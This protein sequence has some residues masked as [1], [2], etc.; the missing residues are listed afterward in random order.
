MGGGS[1]SG[2]GDAPAA[3]HPGMLKDGKWLMPDGAR[4]AV[5]KKELKQWYKGFVR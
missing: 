2:G 4:T 3:A 1:R 5:E